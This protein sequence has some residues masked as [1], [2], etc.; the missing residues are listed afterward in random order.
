VLRIVHDVENL[1]PDNPQMGRP[2]RISGRELVVPRAP[3]IA[4]YRV[5]RVTLQILRVFHAARRWS[6]RF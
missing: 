4:P 2:G 5:Q 1:L 6:D 3:Y